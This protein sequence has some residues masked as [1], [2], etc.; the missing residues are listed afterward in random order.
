MILTII[1]TCEIAFWVVILL[2][3][4]LRYPLRRPRAG[5]VMLALVPL[6]DLILL[7]AVALNLRS[8]ATATFAHSLAALYLGFSI[9]YGHRLIRWADI[10][11]AHRFAGGPAPAKLHGTAYMRLCWADVARTALAAATACAMTWLLIAWVGEPDRTEALASTYQWASFI[12]MIDLLWA[13]SYTIW[14]RKA[15]TAPIG[16]GA[17]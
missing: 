13:V 4:A 16:V 12:L 9:A 5:L 3:L 15:A 2:G 1:V 7:L 14:P 6:V 8:G 10:R 17:R 11:F